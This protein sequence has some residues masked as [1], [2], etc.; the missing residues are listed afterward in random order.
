VEKPVDVLVQWLKVTKVVDLSDFRDMVCGGDKVRAWREASRLIEEGVLRAAAHPDD[1]RKRCLVL[2]AKGAR[3]LGVEVGAHRVIKSSQLE[4]LILRSRLYVRLLTAG[5]RAESILGRK[6]ALEKY[7]LEPQESYLAWVITEP[8]PYC[9][10]VPWPSGYGAKVYRSVNNSEAKGVWFEAHILVHESAE[11]WRYDR[12]RFVRNCPPGRFLL[13]RSDQ[14][15]ELKALPA[16]R[17]KEVEALFKA[18][19]PG[20]NLTRAP[21]GSPL[22]LVYTR[23]GS[24]LVGDMRLDDI[25]LAARVIGLT[26]EM[27]GGWNGV[28]LGVRDEAHAA[29]WARLF[30]DRN[31]LWYLVASTCSLYQYDGR[32]LVY[33]GGGQKHEKAAR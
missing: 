10:Y 4:W 13:L 16:A 32:R 28:T 29:D 22:P 27:V 5:F 23:R 6:E 11:S 12:R 24:M 31:W 18:I 19:A 25:S 14:V 15:G 20:G 8:G 30:G 26:R 3:E 2:T 9:L 7:G 1:G 21:I 17:V 33:V